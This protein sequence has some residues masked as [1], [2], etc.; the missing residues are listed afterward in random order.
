MKKY[1]LVVIG[2]GPAGEK[3]AV[4]A[5]YFGHKAAVVEKAYKLGGA[6][7]QAALPSKTLKQTALY[8][9]GKMERGLYGIEKQLSHEVTI[10]DFMYRKEFVTDTMTREVHNNLKIHGVDLFH[11]SGIIDDPHHVRVVGDKEEVLETEYIL[12]AT[13]SFPTHPDGIPFD[14][15]RVFDSDSILG[16]NHL[17]RSLCIVG[18][19]VI[20]CEYATIFSTM[21][22]HVYLVNRSDVVLPHLDHDICADLLREMEQSGVE[23]LYN[24]SVEEIETPHD[25]EA[26]LSI[27]LVTGE[28]LHVDMFLFAAGRGGQTKGMGL[29]EV[30]VEFGKR[31]RIA[32]NH[33][34]R[35]SVPNI[36]AAGDVIGFPSLA[37]TS[38]DQG[39]A[40]VAHMFNLHDLDQLAT[41]LPYGIYTIPEVGMVGMTEQ[42][43]KAAGLNY[44]VGM[45]RFDSVARGQIMGIKTGLLKLIFTK[46]DQIIRG[47]HCVGPMATELIHYAV[48][49]V[50]GQK[51]LSYIAQAVFNFPTLH[52]VYKAACYD[53]LSN[54]AGH[55]VKEVARL[56]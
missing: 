22:S 40:A 2:S 38:M 30:G 39:R 45:A 52:E 37:S 29:Q 32:V 8:L 34:Y 43:A 3:A 36:F 50:E 49:L 55:K 5:A 10:Q 11:G 20:G 56:E 23:F 51:T 27:R 53:G 54:L 6:G 25:R 9:S 18:A 17:P 7:I 26:P 44:E 15:P 42:D 41:V 21:G 46:E 4:K 13:G 47:V 31:G 16:I 35:T 28:T 1:E 14:D 24:T 19:G 48:V 12:I 33:E